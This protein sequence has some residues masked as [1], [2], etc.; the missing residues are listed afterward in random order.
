VRYK[1]VLDTV[2]RYFVCSYGG[3]A[4]WTL[5][6]FLQNNGVTYH[7]H[8]NRPPE[9]LTLP[10][11]RKL[12]HRLLNY[13]MREHFSN[14]KKHRI[15][16]TSNC[17]VIYLYVKPAY[18]ILSRKAFSQR[19]LKSIGVKPQN[20]KKLK[21]LSRKEYLV[22]R[23]NLID[24]ESFFDNY[25][26]KGINRN[27][28][29]I[30]VNVHKLWDNLPKFFSFT[31]IPLSEIKKFPKKRPHIAEK[32]LEKY[33]KSGYAYGSLNEKIDAMDPI[34]LLKGSE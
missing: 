31:D 2:K 17:Y 33:V 14:R 8:S 4:S 34:T 19:H 9:L 22:G 26:V 24:Y 20:L 21:T 27:Y 28:D 11:S 12:I 10:V 7:I 25:V 13:G 23:T 30:A 16:D 18:S 5:L 1:T 6:Q 3:C 32:L 15:I 29:I